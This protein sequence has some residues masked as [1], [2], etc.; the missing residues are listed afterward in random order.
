MTEEEKA[1]EI[2]DKYLKIEI[3]MFGCRDSNPCIISGNMFL[4]SAKECAK[5][6]V[7]G[8]LNLNCVWYDKEFAESKGMDLTCTVEYWQSVLKAI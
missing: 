7:N 3:S 8:I 1:K 5:K 2:V 6:E 4:A